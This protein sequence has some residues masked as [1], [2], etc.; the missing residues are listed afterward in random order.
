[1]PLKTTTTVY[2]STFPSLPSH[3]YRRDNSLP[4]G[5]LDSQPAHD[6]HPQ[7]S[8][9]VDQ[10]AVNSVLHEGEELME[11]EGR[12]RGGRGGIR[13]SESMCGKSDTVSVKSL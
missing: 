2:S 3:R 7:Q 9:F 11:G 10:T 13:G 1:M 4:Q 6:V 8:E 12:Q 5:Y